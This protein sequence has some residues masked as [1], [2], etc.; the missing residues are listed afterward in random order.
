[1][2]PTIVG[3][4]MILLGFITQLFMIMLLIMITFVLLKPERL[5]QFRNALM[6]VLIITTVG[7]VSLLL[8]STYTLWQSYQQYNYSQ[9]GR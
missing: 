9:T 2:S 8:R 3:Y 5:P 1:M 4:L 6:V 7:S